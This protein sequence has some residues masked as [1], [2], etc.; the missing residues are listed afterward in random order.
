MLTMSWLSSLHFNNPWVI[1]ILPLPWLVYHF[2]PPVTPNFKALVA[3]FLFRI[4]KLQNPKTSYSSAIV[5]KP[6]FI[7]LWL[8]ILLSLSMPVFIKYDIN[9]QSNQHHLLVAL[10]ISDSMSAKDVKLS[11]GRFIT[12]FEFTQT[13]LTQLLEYYGQEKAGLILFGTQPYLISPLTHNHAVI[14]DYLR[15]SKTG[16][17]GEKTSIGEAIYLAIEALKTKQSADHKTQKTLILLTDGSNTTGM[18]PPLESATIA[19][20][21]GIRIYTLG[22]GKNEPNKE[23]SDEKLLN[24]ISEYTG[25]K[26]YH[27]EN[28]QTFSLLVN[29]INKQKKN[30]ETVHKKSKTYPLLHWIIILLLLLS[31]PWLFRQMKGELL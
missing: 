8:L 31:L 13:F 1:G 5:Y 9:F 2:I 15:Y 18:L 3:P 22:V 11:H 28:N 30:K 29:E 25:G 21:E 10:D 26:Y 23:E 16:M 7:I 24:Q 4:A 19:K 27:I 20:H 17:A 12:R 6:Y 14:K